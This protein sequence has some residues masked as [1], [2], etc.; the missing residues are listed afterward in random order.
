M[1]E[2]LDFD[3]IKRAATPHLELLVRGM[4]PDGRMEGI[5]WVARNPLRGDRRLGSF[6]INLLTGKWADFATGDKGG[7]VISLYAY[8]MGVRQRDA[9]AFLQHL[10]ETRNA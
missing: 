2:Y 4:L 3:A 5:E 1:P 6:K 7:D 9:A 8:L 10:L